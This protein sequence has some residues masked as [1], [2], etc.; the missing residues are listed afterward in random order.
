MKYKIPIKAKILILNFK[1]TYFDGQIELHEKKYDV[2]VKANSDKCFIK[3][4]FQ[5]I[6]VKNQNMLLRISARSGI[7]VE[8]HLYYDGKSERLEIES[9]IIFNDIINKHAGLDTI[10][11]FFE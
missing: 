1:D 9:D 4:P 5:I 2:I 6:G 10:E 11:I 8:D 3:L 7:Y